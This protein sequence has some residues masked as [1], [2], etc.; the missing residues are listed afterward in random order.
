VDTLTRPRLLLAFRLLL[1][2]AAI[3]AVTMALLPH[4][5]KSPVEGD[6]WNHMLAF[7]TLTLLWVLAFP[8]AP[9]HRIGERLSFLGALI[10]VFQSIPALHRDCDVIDW[11]A[12]TYVVVCVLVLVRIV[13]GPVSTP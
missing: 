4:P 2:A 9:L 1:V 12:D 10:E 5:P 7:G 6:K 11:A 13:R 3:F 8:R